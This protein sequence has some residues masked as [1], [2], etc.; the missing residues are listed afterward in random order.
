[1]RVFKSKRISDKIFGY[2]MIFYLI[3][4]CAITFWLVEET[5]RS[6][7]LGIM[8]ELKLCE[9]TF[10]QPLVE[11]LWFKQTTEVSSFIQGILQLPEIIGIR[12]IDPNTGQIL[13]RRGWVPHPRDLNP[14][15][16]QQD[17]TVSATSE[18]KKSED[19]FDHRFRLTYELGNQNIAVGE[20]TLFS[21]LNVIIER[22]K[23]R[24]VLI[25][26]GAG[27]QLIVLWIFFSW[28]GRRFL[29]QP[30]LRLKDSVE[31]FDLDKPEETPQSPNMKGDDELAVLSRAFAAMQNRLA[32]TVRTL[33]QKQVE[34]SDLNENLETI[35][36]ERTA[37]LKKV[38]EAVEQSPVSVVIT[39]K[40][41]TIEYVNPTFSEITGYTAE[42]AIG[43]SPRILKSG[44][45]SDSFYKEM[46]D[47]I[48]AG[49]TWKGD[50]INRKKGG[51]GF[52]GECFDFTN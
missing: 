20:V 26:A 18:T 6:A 38:S 28:A 13:I 14:R 50:F 3:V 49:R 43:Q 33:N 5:Y 22:I 34:L 2:T 12:I 35:V 30:L 23:N 25:L 17:E 51:G 15:F 40:T 48:N 44:N 7:K 11:Y 39:D 27:V 47:T 24:V 46:W 45:L 10:S 32:E 37:D 19:I 16:Y 41:G 21:D 52:L 29:S 9:T 8:R 31:S 36:H 4:V 42:E 1:M